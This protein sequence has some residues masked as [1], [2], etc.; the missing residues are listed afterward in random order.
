MAQKAKIARGA[1]D[2]FMKDAGPREKWDFRDKEEQ[3]RLNT[4][5]VG[6]RNMY[7]DMAASYNARAQM[8]NRS[9][10]M[11]KDVPEKIDASME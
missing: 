4:N 5:W 6:T 3:Q 11:G 10:F 8:V 1:L 9:I 7:L 2:Q